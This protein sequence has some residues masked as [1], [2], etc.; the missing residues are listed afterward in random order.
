M[1]TR[2]IKLIV[3]VVT[4]AGL[5]SSCGTSTAQKACSAWKKYEDDPRQSIPYFA[6]LVREDSGYKYL[7]EAID[8]YSTFKA[9]EREGF[10]RYS[11]QVAGS[12][13]YNEV[14]MFCSMPE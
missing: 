8:T 6:E 14:E 13:A 12:D 9:L 5:L 11:E 1:R 4:S 10:T 7:L 2:V 3:T